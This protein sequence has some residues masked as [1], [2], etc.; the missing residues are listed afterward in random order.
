MSRPPPRIPEPA[1]GGRSGLA[2]PRDSYGNAQPYD[3]QHQARYYD[4]DME[5]QDRRQHFQYSE[6]SHNGLTPPEGQY[7]PFSM[8][9]VSALSS[10]A[11]KPT[12]SWQVERY[13]H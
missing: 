5:D 12:V 10:L 6:Q 3:S 7:D 11:L 2:D 8:S 13:R 9:V 4:D 1:H